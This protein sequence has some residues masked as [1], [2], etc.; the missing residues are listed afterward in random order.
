M[1]IKGTQMNQLNGFL[2][3]CLVVLLFSF[4]ASS[5]YAKAGIVFFGEQE[6]IHKIM[7]IK[8]KGAENEALFLGYKTSSY[9]ILAGVYLKDEG[10]VLGVSEKEG[11]YYPFPTGEKLQLLQTM[12]L[13]PAELPEYSI[14]FWDWFFGYSL[15]I[16][17]FVVVVYSIIKIMLSSE[18]T[19][20]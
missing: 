19:Q 8:L 13:I 16:L 18:S 14:S 15:W 9:F 17:I 5:A 4:S 2:R 10:Y 6:N 20:G 12:G 1:S 11:H 3:A 7:D